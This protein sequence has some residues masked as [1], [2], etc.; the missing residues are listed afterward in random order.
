M[1]WANV[2]DHLTLFLDRFTELFPH[3]RIGELSE[4]GSGTPDLAGYLAK[5]H[6]LT[7]KEA[8]ELI[9]DRVLPALSAIYAAGNRAA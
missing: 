7:R 3:A 1:S 5:E 4:L 8:T 6:D 9:E 2:S